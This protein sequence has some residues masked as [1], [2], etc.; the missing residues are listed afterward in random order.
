MASG[1][2]SGSSGPGD[3]YKGRIYTST[4][5]RPYKQ[6]LPP[7]GGYEKINYTRIPAR[8]V[9]NGKDEREKKRWRWKTAKDIFRTFKRKVF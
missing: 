8:A 7:K 2:S 1:P 5:T 6:D 9:V 4:K 3:Q